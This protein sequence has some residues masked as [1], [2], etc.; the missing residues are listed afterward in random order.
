MANSVEKV[1]RKASKFQWFLMAFLIPLL[2]VIAVGLVLLQISGVNVFQEAKKLSENV[3]AL[4]SVLGD[5]E[6]EVK[7]LEN[8]SLNLQAE[9][10]DREAQI[11][12]LETKILDKDNAIKQV[13]LEKEQLEVQ[14]EE[15]RQIQSDNKRAF[16]DVVETYEAMSPKK[17]API[18]VEL[19]DAEAVKILSQVSPD[20]L[21]KIL[22]SML[23]ADAARFTKLLATEGR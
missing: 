13:E 1:E 10:E 11:A 2:T 6:E 14:L 20:Q 15:L 4:Q 23:P 17:A 5:G 19:E 3:P 18:L 21:G 12:K 22:E 8:K 7:E 9:I 16:A